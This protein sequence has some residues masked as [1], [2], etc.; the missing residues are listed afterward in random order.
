M[1]EETP[2]YR[3]PEVSALNVPR[4]L[5]GTDFLEVRLDSIGVFEWHPLPEGRGKPTQVHM[6]MNLEGT[7]DISL[8]IRFKGPGTLDAVIAALATHRFNVW[9]NENE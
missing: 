3:K 7:D 6:V 2:R 1:S 5:D 9:P 4:N 8:I